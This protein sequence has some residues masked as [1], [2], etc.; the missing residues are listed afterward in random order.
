V[1]SYP[2]NSGLNHFPM[3]STISFE[4]QCDYDDMKVQPTFSFLFS[5]YMR[6]EDLITATVKITVL[7][8]VVACGLVDPLLTF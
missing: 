6:F 1:A 4:P 5:L 2:E 3:S 7:W 8:D